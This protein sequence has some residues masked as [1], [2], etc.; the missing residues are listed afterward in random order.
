MEDNIDVHF[1]RAFSG[2]SGERVIKYLRRI[3]IE[4]TL[5]VNVSDSELRTL[6]GQRAMVH[7]IENMI[8]RGQGV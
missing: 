4:R 2:V 1:A 5:G 3:T 7:Q 8:L 6:E